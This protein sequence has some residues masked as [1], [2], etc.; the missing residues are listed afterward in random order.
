MSREDFMRQLE[1][2]L[3]DVPQEEKQEALS[4]YQSYFEDAGVENE[5]R[6]LR[7]LDSPEKVAATIKADLGMG[8][9]SAM[10][11]YTEHGFTDS[12]F[13]DRQEIKV[14]P[15]P[16]QGKAGDR[17]GFGENGNPGY[18]GAYGQEGKKGEA[19]GSQDWY[20]PR[21]NRGYQ[22]TGGE[23]SGA[24]YGNGG[25]SPYNESRSTYDGNQLGRIILLVAIAVF[26][27]PVWLGLLGGIGGIVAGIA[28]AAVCV[29]GSLFIAGGV[30]FGVGIGQMAT[31]GFGVGFALSGAGML[32]LALAVLSTLLCVWAC[33]KLVPWFLR[34]VKGLWKGFFSRKE[35]RL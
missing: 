14:A 23:G 15:S 10:G 20:G 13:Q 27:S 34:A 22:D 35:Q 5:E 24:S 12:R 16:S 21:G 6:I 31:G 32:V 7:E 26:T 8:T 30:M 18:Q 9:E 29:T 17:Y 2:L 25:R 1:T 19:A 33:S 3:A 28:V 11:E 4:Y